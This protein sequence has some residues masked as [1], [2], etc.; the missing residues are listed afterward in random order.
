M[1]TLPFLCPFSTYRWV[2]TQYL[3]NLGVNYNEDEYFESRL[4][5]GQAHV[6]VGLSLSLYQCSYRR[7]GALILEHIDYHR[8]DAHELTE[9]V[10]KIIALDINNWCIRSHIKDYK[11]S[12]A[13][14]EKPAIFLTK[15]KSWS[16]F[17]MIVIMI[18]ISAE[19]DTECI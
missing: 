1:T 4:R 2:Q 9:F 19:Y 14:R 13:E 7:L 8:D 5:V 3:L 18:F 11:A 12:S 10:H 15:G 6:W 16:C 17:I